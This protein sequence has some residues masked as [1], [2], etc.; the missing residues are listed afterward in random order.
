MFYT[1]TNYQLRICQ[2]SIVLGIIFL[3]LVISYEFCG[4]SQA[5]SERQSGE[6]EDD[7]RMVKVTSAH[8]QKRQTSSRTNPQVN[9]QQEEQLLIDDSSN[10]R[11]QIF[12]DQFNKQQSTSTATAS[13]RVDCPTFKPNGNSRQLPSECVRPKTIETAVFVDSALDAKFNGL[14]NGLVELNKLIVTI[15]NQV[16]HLFKYSSMKVPINIKLVLVEHMSVSK[17]SADNQLSLPNSDGGDIDLY[18]SNFCNWQH[19][20]LQREKRLWWDHAILLSG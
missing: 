14:S 6:G 17:N 9:Q 2:I 10:T 4:H 16:Q 11:Q 7:H 8:R 13:S 20:R 1:K 5:H 18:L 19:A 15:M 12:E 3:Q